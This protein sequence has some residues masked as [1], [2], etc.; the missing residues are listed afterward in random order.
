MRIPTA[1]QQKQRAKLQKR[2]LTQL[3]ST[4]R[5][6]AHIL[7]LAADAESEGEGQF[8]DKL[9]ARVDDPDLNK[10]IRIHQADE[11]R[12][13]SMVRAR[14]E[15]QGVPLTSPPDHLKLIVR[16]DKK[17]GG[18]F[19][20]RDISD[21]GE[22][23]EAYVLLQV[24]EERAIGQFALFEEAFRPVDPE[25]ADVF[26]AISRDEERHLKYCRA[27]SK[28]YAA[29]EFTLARTLRRFRELEAVTFAENSRANMRHIL[30]NDLIAATP[31]EKLG[32]WALAGLTEVLRGAEPTKFLGGADER[33]GH[34]IDPLGP[35]LAV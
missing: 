24:V 27:I 16:L 10:M 32:W 5:G 28:R 17:L 33:P 26:A 15:A 29:D 21:R 1:S 12:H 6:R 18:K 11:V 14:A 31:A 25:T 4:P 3:V 8:F 22:I 13:A 2:Y 7:T 34:A 30:W 20:Q 19:F 35:A 9:L 23:M